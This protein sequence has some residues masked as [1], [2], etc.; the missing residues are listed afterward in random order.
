MSPLR[1]SADI[2][3]VS[4]QKD[5]YG[6]RLAYFH[7]TL[8]HD[9]MHSLYTQLITLPFIHVE[10]YLRLSLL[11]TRESFASILHSKSRIHVFV[12]CAYT[13]SRVIRG[14]LYYIPANV[15]LN[16]KTQNRVLMGV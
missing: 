9:E 1:L 3:H 13:E 16:M 11:T 15:P 2:P 7:Y 8:A 10:M 5:T 14:L 6:L 12:G 4:T